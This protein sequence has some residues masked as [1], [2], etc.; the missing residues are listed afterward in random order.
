[1]SLACF[2]RFSRLGMGALR[3]TLLK[4]SMRRWALPLRP[5]PMRPT[6]STASMAETPDICQYSNATDIF[7][8]SRRHDQRAAHSS[9][10]LIRQSIFSRRWIRGSTPHDEMEYPRRLLHHRRGLP[11]QQLA[12]F[13]GA[14]RRLA[15][16]RIDLFGHRVGAQ[17]GR[18]LADGLEPAL[19]VRKVVD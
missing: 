12:L 8:R 13:L 16:I 10:D 6:C 7:K 3:L 1:M 9:P 2:L 5:K 4:R 18:P 19:E 15:E 11:E 17:R 14:D